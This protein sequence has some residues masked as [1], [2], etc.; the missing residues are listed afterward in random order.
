MNAMNATT[1]IAHRAALHRTAAERYRAAAR[2]LAAIPR[3]LTEARAAATGRCAGLV[4]LHTEAAER[5]EHAL[6]SG[7]AAEVDATMAGAP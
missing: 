6:A 3:P 5:Y 7:W 1:L 2:E 4:F